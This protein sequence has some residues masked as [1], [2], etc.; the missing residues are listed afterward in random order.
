MKVAKSKAFGGSQSFAAGPLK[1]SRKYV[2]TG[3]WRFAQFDYG[4]PTDAAV[5]KT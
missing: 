2:S 1:N 3:G 4:E 5:H